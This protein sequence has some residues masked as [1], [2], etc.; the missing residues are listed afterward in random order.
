MDRPKLETG[1]AEQRFS[2]A[3]DHPK[4]AAIV[5]SADSTSRQ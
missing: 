5:S 2:A 3:R 1:D 4:A